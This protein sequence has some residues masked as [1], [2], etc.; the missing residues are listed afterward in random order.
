MSDFSK[1]EINK[2]VLHDNI[3][4]F[5]I[6]KEGNPITE[7]KL[8]D[9]SGE[10]IQIQASIKD[11][12][13]ETPSLISI[14]DSSDIESEV[15]R[16]INEYFKKDTPIKNQI[17]FLKEDINQLDQKGDEKLKEN[18]GIA[19]D[20]QSLFGEVVQKATKEELQI[21]VDSA[22]ASSGYDTVEEYKKAISEGKVKN[23]SRAFF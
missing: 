3:R 11:I 23:Y 22:R 19:E 13:G 15:K 4:V 6:N 21:D 12:E 9:K 16:A 18:Y 5:K 14:I 10:I 7:L 1:K 20:I 2:N 8:D 17:I